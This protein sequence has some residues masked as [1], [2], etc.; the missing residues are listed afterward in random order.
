MSNIEP[1]LITIDNAV[2]G[3][4]EGRGNLGGEIIF[5]ICAYSSPQ[6]TSFELLTVNVGHVIGPPF[7]GIV[8]SH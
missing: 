2:I 4:L 8:P 6:A 3:F 7:C 5:W 1:N